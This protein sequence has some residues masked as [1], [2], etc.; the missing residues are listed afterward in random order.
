M[1]NIL[2]ILLLTGLT[3]TP[4]WARAKLIPLPEATAAALAGK[5][6]AITRRGEKPSFIAAT[7]GKATFAL[8]GVGAMVAEGNRI[9]RDNSIADPADTLET[10]LVPALV[11]QY[12]VKLTPESGHVITPGN[13]LKQI[14]A[15]APGADLILD[16]RSIGWNFNYYPTHWGTYWV[17]YG[18]QVQLI[19]TKSSTVVSN[20]PC[21]NN[22]MK[23]AAAPSKEALLENGAQLLKDVLASSSWTC[24]L[25]LAKEQFRIAPENLPKMPAA[26]TDPLAAFAAKHSGTAST[27]ATEAAAPTSLPPPSDAPASQPP[28]PDPAVA[29]AAPADH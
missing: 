8:L 7:A 18:V 12:G 20:M 19:D 16:I 11:K 13:D 28:T 4:S 9:V 24:T 22:T 17:G 5:T 2:L 29:P 23:N 3:A 25:L 1:R 10:E 6:L 27:P 26:L 21:G 14:I 15:A